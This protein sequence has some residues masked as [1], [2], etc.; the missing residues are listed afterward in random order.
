M[1]VCICM[2]VFMYVCMYVCMCVCMYVFLHRLTQNQRT[3]SRCSNNT[4]SA[5]FAILGSFDNTRQIQQLDLCS[6][7]SCHVKSKLHLHVALIKFSIIYFTFTYY[8]LDGRS[9][10]TV[11][12][13]VT[14]EGRVSRMIP[15][16]HVNVVNSYA[17]A[18]VSCKTCGVST[19]STEQ[20]TK[21]MDTSTRFFFSCSLW[22]WQ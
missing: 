10:P 9:M 17:A 2:D 11:R 5:T 14:G 22:K 4:L 1:Y 13:W 6:L 19:T 12:V 3:R 15:G 18:S 8:I 7:V 16:M 20:K 21:N